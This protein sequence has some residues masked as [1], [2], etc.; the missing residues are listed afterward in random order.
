MGPLL[1]LSDGLAEVVDLMSIRAELFRALRR[2]LVDVIRQL[3]E[4]FRNVFNAFLTHECAKAKRF[5]RTLNLSLT[6][7]AEVLGDH[8]LNDLVVLHQIGLVLEEELS[9]R[10]IQSVD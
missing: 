10:A 2:K 6:G 1:E 5:E 3:S 7:I 9:G 4:T 8:H